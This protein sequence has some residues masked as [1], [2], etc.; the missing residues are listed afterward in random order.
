[1]RLVVANR[2]LGI[3]E[4]AI[5]TMSAARQFPEFHEAWQDFLFRIERAWEQVEREIRSE[6]G[7][8]QWFKPYAKLKKEDPLLLFLAHARNVE[9]HAVS[10][11][12]DKPMRLLMR[13]KLGTPFSIKSIRSTLEDG[14]LTID[15]D[16]AAHDLLLDYEVRLLPAGPVLTSFKDR[17]VLYEIPTSHLKRPL[18]GVNPIEAARLGLGFYRGFIAEAEFRFGV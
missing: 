11:T 13:D 8:Q 3:A 5:A 12:V 4:H 6:K 16:T 17:G 14:T 10:A 1:M 7:F 2:D 18:N 15:I 9:T